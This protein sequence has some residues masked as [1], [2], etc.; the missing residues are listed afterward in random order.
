MKTESS[1][2][3]QT[4]SISA[5][6]VMMLVVLVYFG[7]CWLVLAAGSLWAGQAV[8][9]VRGVP[10]QNFQTRVRLDA[11]GSGQLWLV[12]AAESFVVSVW[13]LAVLELWLVVVLLVALLPGT[14][15]KGCGWMLYEYTYV[16]IL[17]IAYC[18][19]SA[20]LALPCSFASV[21]LGPGSIHK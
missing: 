5:L 9:E 17:D 16:C 21:S 6:P 20:E 14:F 4:S 13:G 11:G 10:S 8:L 2:S 7:Q 12:L 18:Q 3:R 1:E 15:K 19:A